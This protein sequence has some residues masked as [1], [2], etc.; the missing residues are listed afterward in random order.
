MEILK[1]VLMI[2]QMGTA[3]SFPNGDDGVQHGLADKITVLCQS[4]NSIADTLHILQNTPKLKSTK[5]SAFTEENIR[6]CYIFLTQIDSTYLYSEDC[7]YSLLKYLRHETNNYDLPYTI[8]D[9]A[10]DMTNPQSLRKI[11]WTDG[12]PLRIFE[13]NNIYNTKFNYYTEYWKCSEKKENAPKYPFIKPVKTELRKNLSKKQQSSIY[14]VLTTPIFVFSV[15]PGNTTPD[16]VFGKFS[17][18]S[19]KTSMISTKNEKIEGRGID[20][21]GDNVLDAFWYVDI[22]DSPVAEWYARLYIN[23]GGEWYPTWYTYFKEL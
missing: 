11:T 17:G 13:D 21:N 9:S 2:I 22:V 1:V 15:I 20:L 23:I 6:D 12:I 16:S 5:P 18:K 19:A 10:N 4:E 14:D 3:P 8:S 7:D